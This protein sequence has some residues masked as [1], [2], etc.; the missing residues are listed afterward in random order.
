[1]P[2]DVAYRVLASQLRAA[3]QAGDYNDG[4]PLPTEEQLTAIHSVSRTTVRRA[5]QDLVAEGMVYRVAGR[6]TYVVTE[7]DKYVTTPYI[8]NLMEL[9]HDGKITCEIIAGLETRVDVEAAGR[10]RLDSDMVAALALRRLSDGVPRSVSYVALPF[11]IGRLLTDDDF[12]DLTGNGRLT[13]SGLIDRRMSKIMYAELSISPVILTTAI[14][15]QLEC[16]P[17]LPAL[18]MDRI[19]SDNDG[20]PVELAV[21]YGNPGFYTYRLKLRRNRSE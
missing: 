2:R 17:G 20:Q 7:L 4:R 3:I 15:E 18:R 8:D 6:G 13:I 1:V 10:L 14:A 11:A 16:D 19:Y 12:A 21:S 5:M 9:P